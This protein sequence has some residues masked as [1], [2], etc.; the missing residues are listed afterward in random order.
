[1]GFSK[2]KAW[3]LVLPVF[4][5]VAILSTAVTVNFHWDTWQ[6]GAMSGLNGW[7]VGT[8]LFSFLTK[9]KTEK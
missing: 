5:V 6:N 9:T 8:I 1:M 7:L 2:F 4:F 3:L